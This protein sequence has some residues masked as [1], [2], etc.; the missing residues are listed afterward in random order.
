MRFGSE[1][2]VIHFIGPNKPW[3]QL[4]FP[5]PGSPSQLVAF[6]AHA[7]SNAHYAYA[8]PALVDRWFAV[9][10]KHYRSM[11]PIFTTSGE[12][13]PS[14]AFKEPMYKNAWNSNMR[15]GGVRFPMG[16]DKLRQLALEG[17]GQ[18]PTREEGE[19]AY[20]TLPL[21]GRIYLIFEP[22]H[23]RRVSPRK[24]Q[25]SVPNATPRRAD[26]GSVLT[27]ADVLPHTLTELSLLNQPDCHDLVSNSPSNP[28]ATSSQCDPWSGRYSNA[29]DLIPGI[30]KYASYH[31]TGSTVGGQ[32]AMRHR[33]E[34]SIPVKIEPVCRAWEEGTS[35]DGDDEAED[36]D[37]EG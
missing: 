3:S 33:E 27:P 10:D 36:E 17:L 9:Y 11:T 18:I 8:Y 23:L 13:V 28:A 25:N 21:D 12:L 20:M 16:L 37:R 7:P 24:I 6:P 31:R 22:S 5:A 34:V 2:K 26:S 14:A 19:G 15:S 30:Q 1:I 29:W 32:S 4:P 35:R